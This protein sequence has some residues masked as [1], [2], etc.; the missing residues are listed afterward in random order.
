[1]N[2]QKL[3]NMKKV[4]MMMLSLLMAFPAVAQDENNEDPMQVLVGKRFIDVQLKDTQGTPRKLSEYVGKGNYVL[5]DFWASWCQYCREE[6]PALKK[7]YKKFQG[8][9][10]EVVGL[11]I[12]ENTAN[13]KEAIQQLGLPWTHLDDTKGWKSKAISA[14][15][16]PGIPVNVLVD[17]TGQIVASNLSMEDLTEYLNE[18]LK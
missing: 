8:K 12:D 14:Y 3:K 10:F 7:V 9:G 13:W 11:S 17:P 18:A 2:E 15:K 4:L 5:I 6:M 1:M 16:V